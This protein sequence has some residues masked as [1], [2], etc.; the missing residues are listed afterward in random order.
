MHDLEV[1][2]LTGA[3]GHAGQTSQRWIPYENGLDVFKSQNKLIAARPCCIG[4]YG[5][6]AFIADD[7]RCV[8]GVNGSYNQLH[9]YRNVSACEL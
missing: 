8:V 2:R 7:A 6:Y 5:F 9:L 3:S 1:T 4:V